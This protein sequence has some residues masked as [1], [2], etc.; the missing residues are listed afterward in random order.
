MSEES[1]GEQFFGGPWHGR[2]YAVRHE[3]NTY[4]FVVPLIR[5][6][7]SIYTPESS[8]DRIGDSEV[9][10]T[11][12]RAPFST[13]RVWVAPDFTYDGPEWLAFDTEDWVRR[14]EPDVTK[15]R[16]L[17]DW[18]WRGSK[19][20]VGVFRAHWLFVL[21]DP[22]GRGH[23]RQ[24]TPEELADDASF[25]MDVEIERSMRQEMNYQFLPECVVPDCGKKAPVVYRVAEIRGGRLAGRAYQHGDEVRLCPEHNYD[26]LRAQGVYGLDQLAD[27]LKPDAM[28]DTLDAYDAG[29]DL[30]FGR[31]IEHARSRMLRLDVKERS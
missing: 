25:D 3:P 24:V 22:Q 30:L 27:W 28:L 2:Y 14:L 18:F 7:I 31:E 16:R 13:T 26:V 19:E 10:Y 1:V 23:L 17:G 11:R 4:H 12:R 21:G 29:T 15:W 8:S 5:P 9:M 6:A 20:N